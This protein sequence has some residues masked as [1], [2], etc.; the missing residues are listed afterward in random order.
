M[1]EKLDGAALAAAAIVEPERGDG[2][3]TGQV[4]AWQ[5]KLNAHLDRLPDRGLAAMLKAETAQRVQAAMTGNGGDP[6]K[7][8]T[9]ADA[10]EP[11]PPVEYLV[12]GLL[13]VPSLAIV[14]GPPGCLKSFLMADLA[15]SVAGGL[16]WLPPSP[17]MTTPT[18]ISTVPAARRGI[19]RRSGDVERNKFIF[20]IDYFSNKSAWDPVRSRIRRFPF[21]R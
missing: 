21:M 8:Y 2:W 17:G 7:I 15:A 11:R 20:L 18:S 16:P 9:L 14:Y 13:A 1:T 4:E 3:D 5:H 10:Y 6:W 19:C 12:G